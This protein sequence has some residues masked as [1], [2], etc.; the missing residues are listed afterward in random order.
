MAS[1]RKQFG[2]PSGRSDSASTVAEAGVPCELWGQHGDWHSKKAHVVYMKSNVDSL[3]SVSRAAMRLPNASEPA[4][5]SKVVP[6]G[7]HQCPPVTASVPVGAEDPL[8]KD[9]EVRA[10]E[11][12]AGARPLVIDL[13]PTWSGC[14]QERSCGLA[15]NSGISPWSFPAAILPARRLL[16]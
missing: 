4:G 5:R 13:P 6:A 3:L 11:E 14:R 16:G 15:G 10:A 2:P 12:S 9:E 8:D 7:A 1:F